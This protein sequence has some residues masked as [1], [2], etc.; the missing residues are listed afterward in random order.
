MMILAIEFSSLVRSV[1]LFRPGPCGGREVVGSVSDEGARS[2]K[3]LSL[4]KR[5][6]D[7]TKT[8]PGALEAMVVG[9]GPGSYTG[10]RSSIALAQGWQLAHW[11]KLTGVSSVD[12]LALQAQ[13]EGWFGRVSIVLDAQRNEFYVATYELGSHRREIVEPLRLIGRADL[14]GI[15]GRPNALLIG[16]EASKWSAGGRVLYPEARTLG[17]LVEPGFTPVPGENLEPIYLR[18]TSFAKAPPL[19]IVPP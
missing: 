13:N 8:L 16:P 9:L 6:L 15:S 5:L 12:C 17:L 19:R 1:A 11:I 4:I 14:D 3:P 10:I 7:E 18:V 2:V